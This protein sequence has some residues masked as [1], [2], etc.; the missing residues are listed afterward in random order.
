MV[1]ISAPTGQEQIKM[2]VALVQCL[3]MARDG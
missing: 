2:D 3:E 1:W